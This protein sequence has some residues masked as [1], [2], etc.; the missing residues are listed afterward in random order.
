MT[1]KNPKLKVTT[2]YNIQTHVCYD[3][4]T[5]DSMFTKQ[6]TWSEERVISLKRI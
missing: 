3:C 6:L 5:R 1:D 2:D 4:L